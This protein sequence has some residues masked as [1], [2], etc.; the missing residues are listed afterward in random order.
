MDKLLF[1]VRGGGGGV[2]TT[3]HG[4]NW[5]ASQWNQNAMVASKQCMA[6][7][8]SVF[9]EHLYIICDISNVP[10]MFQ[11]L[12]GVCISMHVIAYVCYSN[13][14]LYFNKKPASS[15]WFWFV[16]ALPANPDA[17]EGV[18]HSLF[19]CVGTRTLAH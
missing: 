6:N 17:I 12:C 7:V 11:T 1:E 2:E 10:K 14:K 18:F 19:Y 13:Q 9:V 5:K 4:S 3:N 15:L 8:T 16:S